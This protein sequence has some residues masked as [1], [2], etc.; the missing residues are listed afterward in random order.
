M[1]GLDSSSFGTACKIHRKEMGTT[2]E[3]GGVNTTINKNERVID[4]VRQKKKKLVR[5]LS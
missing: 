1:L 4:N 3:V 5:H 2:E